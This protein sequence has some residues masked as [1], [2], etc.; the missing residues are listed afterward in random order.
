MDRL[1]LTKDRRV[2]IYLII[3]LD[4]MDRLLLLM[5]MI[6]IMIILELKATRKRKWEDAYKRHIVRHVNLNR[7]VFENDRLCIENI[8]MD[9]RTFHNLCHMVRETGRLE[10]TKNMTIEEQLAIFLHILAHDVKNRIIQRQL[11]RSGETVSRVVNK[12]LLSLLRC[13]ALLLKRP[14]PIPENSTDDHWKYFKNCLGALDGTYIKVNVQE[15]DIPRYRTRKNKI[16]TNVLGVCSPDMQFIYVLPGWEG[17]TADSRVLRDAISR[18]NGLVV[19]RG[20]YY[21]CDA[22]YSNSEGFLTPYRGERYHL[23]TWGTDHLP[24]TPREYFNMRHSRAR[25]VIERAFGML[26][27]RW[28]ILRSKSYYPVKTQCRII[29]ACCLLHNHIRQQMAV[30]PY[31]EEEEQVDVPERLEGERI[32]FVESS[33]AWSAWRD[34]LAQELFNSWNGI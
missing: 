5:T 27:G 21:L 9:R 2:L 12:V 13:Q 28:A 25:N 10:P 8:R 29:I 30:D 14:E 32:R 6:F 11:M 18:R 24:E 15:G 1:S 34:N 4:M 33:N 23:K 19:P 31:E 22:G 26:K 20:Y 3:Q 16:A 7:I 17:S